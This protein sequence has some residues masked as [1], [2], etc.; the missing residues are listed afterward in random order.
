M[1]VVVYLFPYTL[2]VDVWCLPARGESCFLA[3]THLT[4]ARASMSPVVYNLFMSFCLADITVWTLAD[5]KELQSYPAQ[6]A[7]TTR[8]RTSIAKGSTRS[9]FMTSRRTTWYYSIWS[10]ENVSKLFSNLC[11]IR[12]W[13]RETRDIDKTMSE[14]CTEQAVPNKRLNLLLNGIWNK[15]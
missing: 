15:R 5:A 3:S 8:P 1:C 7:I 10:S 4:T 13:A 6:Q 2:T 11:I 14:K 9:R 12:L